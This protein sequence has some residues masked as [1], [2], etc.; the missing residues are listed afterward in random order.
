MSKYYSDLVS[1]PNLAGYTL[2]QY[3]RAGPE[4][5]E[6]NYLT[7]QILGQYTGALELKHLDY[8]REFIRRKVVVGLARDLPTSAAVFHQVFNWNDADEAMASHEGCYSDIFHAL[9][10][11]AP[12]S[13]EEGS[14]GWK[15]L[16]A[17]N[18]FD[19]K[20][21]EYVEFLFDE[22]LKQ[23]DVKPLA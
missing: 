11:K 22:Q 16:V 14:E 12:P 8:A 2:P 7:R 18:W 23:L 9:S 19:L 1:N 15:L 10:D 21:Y 6:N 4:F 13:I 5:V 3:V 17:Q 20:V